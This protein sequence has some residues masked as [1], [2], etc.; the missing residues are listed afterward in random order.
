MEI[1]LREGHVT[2]IRSMIVD[3][4]PLA[5]ERIRSLLAAQPDV[6]IVAECASGR[7]AVEACRLHQPDLMFLD[8]QM[9]ELDGFGVLEELSSNGGKERMPAV[10][11]VTA[12]GQYALRAFEVR[13]LDFLLKPFDDERF[14][15]AMERARQQ[16]R[17]SAAGRGAAR[18]THRRLLALVEDMK[19]RAKTQDRLV[20]RSGGRVFFLRTSEIDWIE[21]A[22]NYVRLHV[23]SSSHLLRETMNGI[24]ARLDPARFLRIHRS[25]IV[26]LERVRQLEPWF[27][28][29]Y[30]V[31]LED[32]TR[33]TLSRGH[34]EKLDRLMSLA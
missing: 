18:T 26:N 1:A 25:T 3:E 4:E 13:A 27:H 20:V 2:P 29:D 28:G 9:P 5:R 22:S 24:E 34:R 12:Y 11:F 21:A 16:L 17:I 6:Q 31:I 8:V 7:Q 15:D 14:H 19:G 30:A 23:G 32:G 10:I 33:L